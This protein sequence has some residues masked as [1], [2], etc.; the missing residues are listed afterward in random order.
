MP[1]P[2]DLVGSCMG[3]NRSPLPPSKSYKC[4]KYASQTTEYYGCYSENLNVCTDR[5]EFHRYLARFHKTNMSTVEEWELLQHYGCAIQTN[6]CSVSTK[7]DMLTPLTPFAGK[8]FLIK[9]SQF[10]ATKDD[11]RKDLS[12][13]LGVS[14][15]NIPESKR[16][17]PP[18]VLQICDDQYSDIRRVLLNHASR[19]S[20]WILTYF[21]QSPDVVVSSREYFVEQM[22][23]WK[24]DPCHSKEGRNL[25]RRIESVS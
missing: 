7:N 12:N 16:T 3:E 9:I 15:P 19:S 5:A 11:L 10:F 4:N 6:D 17:S 24:K 13:Y 21:L 14:L 1:P 22:R 20:E 8:I 2:R 18:Q 25:L 23:S